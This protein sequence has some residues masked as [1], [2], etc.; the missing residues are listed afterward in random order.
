VKHEIADLYEEYTSGRMTRRTFLDRLAL[1]AGGSAAA[2]SLLPALQGQTPQGPI[3]AEDDK[4]LATSRIE[5]DGGDT[6]IAAYLARLKAPAR[7]PAVIVIHENR[8]LTPHIQ[9]VAR[10]VAVE[11][12]LALAPDML[13]PVGGTPAD[14][15]QAPKLFSSLKPEETVAR[16]AAAVKFLAAHPDSTGKV[17][18]VGFCWGG[19]MVNSLAAAGT[20]LKAGVSYYGRVLPAADVPKVNAALLLQYASLDERINAGIPSSKRR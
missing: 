3:V 5:Y 18:V 2:L 9:D 10:R 11:G 15:E 16:L 13:T 4:R 12:F 1:V 6:K 7:R 14:Q 20:A 19:G 17:G 8:G